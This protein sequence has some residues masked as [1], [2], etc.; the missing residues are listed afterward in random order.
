MHNRISR[1]SAV[2][3]NAATAESALAA[4]RLKAI[5]AI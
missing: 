4:R 1:L 3:R 2:Q 5:G